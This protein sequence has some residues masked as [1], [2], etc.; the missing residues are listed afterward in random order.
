MWETE[1][2]DLLINFILLFYIK[3][4]YLP[5]LDYFNFTNI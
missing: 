3:E 2:P 4:V 1:D 5:K